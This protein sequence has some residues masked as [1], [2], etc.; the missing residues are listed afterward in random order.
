MKLQ[1]L[2]YVL[3]VENT[4]F[5]NKGVEVTQDGKLLIKYAKSILAT[6]NLWIK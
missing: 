4:G 6:K 5:T 1:Q 2:K 3:E